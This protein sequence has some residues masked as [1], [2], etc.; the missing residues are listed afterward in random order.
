M[1]IWLPLTAC[2]LTMANKRRICYASLVGEIRSCTVCYQDI[3][4][5]RH[6]VEVT[7]ES[8]YEAAVLG[9]NTLHVA[10]WHN[11]P[12]LTIEVRVKAPEV[13]HTIS[14]AVLAAWLAR[15][16]KSPREQAL[17]TRLKELMRL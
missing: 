2:P 4:G 3:E 1:T 10:N 8:L 15:N 9:M 11:A 14:N 12:N 7:A 16:G 5:V 17:K 6:S 13:T